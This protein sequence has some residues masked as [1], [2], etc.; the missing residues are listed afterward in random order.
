MRQILVEHARAR[1]AVKRTAPPQ[2]ADINGPFDGSLEDVLQLHHSL[3]R[4]GE[5]DE[6]KARIVELHYFGGLTLPEM[7]EYMEL[8]VPTVVR[9]LRFAK[10]WLTREMNSCQT[11]T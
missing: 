11:P 2:N 8:S 10:A 3:E 6:R 1:G 4:L 5:V 9:D 7:A